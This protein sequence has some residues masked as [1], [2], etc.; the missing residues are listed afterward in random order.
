[1][2]EKLHG[3]WMI[4]NQYNDIRSSGTVGDLLARLSEVSTRVLWFQN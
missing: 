3:Q 1:M 4:F 2:K